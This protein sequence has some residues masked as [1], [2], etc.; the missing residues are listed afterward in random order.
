MGPGLPFVGPRCGFTVGR[1]LDAGDVV[2]RVDAADGAAWVVGSRYRAAV[3]LPLVLRRDVDGWSE[4][5]V[6]LDTETVTAGLHDVVALPS[7]GVWTVG[8]LRAAEPLAYRWDG[9]EFHAVATPDLGV[10][11]EWLGVGGDDRVGVWAVGKRT[12]GARYRT[13]VG[14]AEGDRFVV[15]PSPNE[16]DGN[17]VLADADAA[18]D[19]VW[20]VGW[21]YGA[22]ARF[23]PLAMRL[24]SD[25][26]ELVAIPAPDGD[27]FLTTVVAGADGTAWAVGWR[28]IGEEGARALVLR[29]DG[30]SWTTVASPSTAW[31][32]LLGA[33]AVDGRLL[34][35]GE[36]R[37]DGRRISPVAWFTDDAGAIWRP[38]PL[39]GDGTRWFTDVDLAAA[40]AAVAVGASSRGIQRSTGFLATGC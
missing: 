13:L 34:V 17:N 26:W 35:V 11:A 19:V 9:T 14:R 2:R 15:V 22:D 30:A 3:G 29:F 37:D 21:S 33:D 36:G 25:A 5:A 10:E 16:G 23:H 28:T 7:G 8:S 38:A 31:A 39:D 32:R 18:G 1:T 12:D 6:P 27:A 4:V 20:A 24:A 40:E